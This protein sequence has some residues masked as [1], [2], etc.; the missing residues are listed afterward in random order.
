MRDRRVALVLIGGLL[1]G[2]LI[3]PRVAGAV[4]NL[5]TVQNAAGSQ[6]AGVT[7]AQQLQTAEAAPSAFREFS[8]VENSGGCT[9]VATIPSTKAFVIRTITIEVIDPSTSGIEAVLVFPNGTCANN[10]IVSAPTHVYGVNTIPVEPGFAVRA[11]GKISVLLAAPSTV[12]TQVWGYL[13]PK[14]AATATTPIG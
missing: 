13:V 11:G 9:V 7:K 10:D 5:V 6:K 1:V 12:A 4:G 3:G 2:W 14:A 8:H